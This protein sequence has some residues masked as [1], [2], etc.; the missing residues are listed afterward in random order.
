MT[1]PVPTAAPRRLAEIRQLT[2]LRGIA[3]VDVMVSHL[4]GGSHAWFELIDDANLA[5]DLFFCLSAFMLCL[6]YRAGAGV[7][8]D[9]RDFAVARIARLYPLYLIG[10]GLGAYTTFRFSAGFSTYH[11]SPLLDVL[12]QLVL[13]NCWPIIGNG[14]S[15][16]G[17]SW[18]VSVE[19]LC[20]AVCFPLLFA[21]SPRAAR[22]SATA[23][24]ALI[25][26]LGFIS[27]AAFMRFFDA[28]ITFLWNG[29]TAPLTALWVLPVRGIAMFAAGWLAYLSY[30]ARDTLTQAT[31]AL[32]DA[33]A[34]LF[35]LILAG[36]GLH[37]NDRHI[38][39]II[40]PF[41]V[42]ALTNPHSVTARFLASRPVHYLGMISFSIY[43]LHVPILYL[44]MFH[45][46]AF[47]TAPGV[48]DH[49]L[50]RVMVLGL[51]TLAASSITY[52]LIEAPGRRW[53]RRLFALRPRAH[54]LPEPG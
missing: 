20:Y 4:S 32:T 10:L 28:R 31:T 25:V 30:A 22:L 23:R 40:C 11:G 17:P 48:N 9:V 38:G 44:G 33:I 42:L 34:V 52:A 24:A 47:S 43:L 37:V 21:L 46:Q 27:F 7:K 14:I 15:W 18:S 16:D 51:L 36:Q 29:S 5:V 54:G 39:V 50:L 3:A 26:L 45:F 35:L 8:L 6:V 1:L 2:G 12:R 41:L 19:M 13:V 49:P 53:L